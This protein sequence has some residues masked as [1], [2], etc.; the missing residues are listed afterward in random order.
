MESQTC[1][2]NIQVKKLVSCKVK[3]AVQFKMSLT[4]VTSRILLDICTLAF[5]NLLA[6]EL[7]AQWEM[8][9]TSF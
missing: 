1:S 6:S 9:K 3:F 5:I 2:K 8:Q 4:A 7:N